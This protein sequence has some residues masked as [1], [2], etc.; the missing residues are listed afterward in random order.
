MNSCS[1]SSFSRC[2]I[3]AEI[4]G[5]DTAMRCDAAAIELASAGAT[6]Y[7]KWRR[8][9]SIS[10]RHRATRRGGGVGAGEASQGSI[11]GK[12]AFPLPPLPLLGRGKVTYPP[13]RRRSA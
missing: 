12:R 8:V 4:D 11:Q 2:A 3:A 1:P 10:E 9:K 6:K 7:C 13:A 5:G